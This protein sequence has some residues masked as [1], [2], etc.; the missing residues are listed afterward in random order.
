MPES[1]L[2][3]MAHSF[4]L[5]YKNELYIIH[6]CRYSCKPKNLIN[7]ANI[8]KLNVGVSLGDSLHLFKL[9]CY[10]SLCAR[11]IVYYF[12]SLIVCFMLYTTY[13]INSVIETTQ[14]YKLSSFLMI[15]A[16]DMCR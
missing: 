1:D 15:Y 3:E 10:Y 9:K 4:F 7:S 5:Y 12:N 16:F 13:A 8:K 6:S 14:T 11:V 2:I